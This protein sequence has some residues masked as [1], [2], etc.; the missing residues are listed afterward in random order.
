[1]GPTDRNL[2]CLEDVLRHMSLTQFS[3]NHVLDVFHQ[4]LIE[5]NTGLHQTEEHN[6]LVCVFWTAL[7]NTY[8]VS[9]LICEMGVQYAIYLS[10]A[11]AHA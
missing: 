10:G 4:V 3:P 7:T 9:K 5:R 1:M 8:R 6:A 2:E 11:K